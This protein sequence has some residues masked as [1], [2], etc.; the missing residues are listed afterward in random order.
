MGLRVRCPGGAGSTKGRGAEHTI[1]GLWSPAVRLLSPSALNI[2]LS[3]KVRCMM[4]CLWNRLDNRNA[5]NCSRLLF[6]AECRLFTICCLPPLNIP[7]CHKAF[8]PGE[9]GVGVRP[10]TCQS[11]YNLNLLNQIYNPIHDITRSSLL[12]IT[13]CCGEGERLK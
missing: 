12:P 11:N 7:V 4:P 9:V 6:S 2:I 1:V 10:V 8:F 5:C 13:G 3:L